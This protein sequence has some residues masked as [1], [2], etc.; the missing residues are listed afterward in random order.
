[1]NAAAQTKAPPEQQIALYTSRAEISEA[2]GRFKAGLGIK[3]ASDQE[4]VALA[5]LCLKWG[6]DPFHGEAYIIPNN[7]VM[8]GI[9][10][11][12]KMA[13]RQ[14]ERLGVRWWVEFL[15]VRSKEECE[16]YGI[17]DGVKAA[18]VC[19]LRRSDHLK[20]YTD[21]LTD[22][23][24]LG[25]PFEQ[26]ITI[27]GKPPVVV[28]IGY[29]MANEQSKMPLPQQAR[30]RAE[31]HALKQAWDVTDKSEGDV[32]NDRI[33]D[34]EW[35]EQQYDEP[36]SDNDEAIEYTEHL[37]AMPRYEEEEPD[38]APAHWIDNAAT[39]S[40]FWAWA[41]EHKMDK[42][43]VYEALGVSSVHYFKGTMDEAKRIMTDYTE[44][45]DPES[46]D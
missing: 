11:L 22:L 9:K 21:T 35:V 38:P 23:Q 39:R 20:A 5:H 42:R 32:I 8:V 12:R 3:N 6:L 40:H 30:K 19:H 36:I 26:L 31:A 46:E 28:G 29:V 37:P 1:M 15:E 18:A 24:K 33:L 14:A 44:Q 17:P 34:T 25:L 16:K 27:I 13:N 4:Y 2:K 41:K 10:G 43:E 45:V 7:G